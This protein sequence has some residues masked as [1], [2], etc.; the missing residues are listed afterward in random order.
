MEPATVELVGADIEVLCAKHA[1][2]LPTEGWDEY[3]AERYARYL[4]DA[5]SRLW[6][7]EGEAFSSRNPLLHQI[8]LGV[9]SYLELYELERARDRLVA[10]G[11][12]PRLTASEREGLEFYREMLKRREER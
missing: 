2:E 4:E 7:L 10:E 3:G 9:R 8:A 1:R 5:A 11:G 6:E 12:T